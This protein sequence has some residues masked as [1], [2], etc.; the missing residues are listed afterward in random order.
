M[1]NFSLTGNKKIWPLRW[2]LSELLFL[3]VQSY[4]SEGVNRERD[5]GIREKEVE[6]HKKYDKI[7]WY[8][9]ILLFHAKPNFFE[10]LICPSSILGLKIG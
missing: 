7:T 4:K 6:R 1:V 5:I 8:K 9:E 3:K 10:L 2:K